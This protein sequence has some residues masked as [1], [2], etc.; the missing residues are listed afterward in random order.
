M[1]EWVIGVDLGRT[2]IALGLIDAQNRIIAHHRMPTRANEGAESV[3]AR[4]AQSVEDLR[5]VMPAHAAIR[6][7]GIC[8]PGPVDYDNGVIGEVHEMQGLHHAPLRAMLAQRL[9]LPVSLDHDAKAA[10]LGEFHYGAGKGERAMVYIVVGT[11]VGAAIISDGRIYRGVRNSAGEIGHV[12]LNR[13]GALCPCGSRGCV[14]TYLSGPWLARRY[15]HR[16]QR[17]GTPEAEASGELVTARAQHGE[18]IAVQVLHEAGEALGAAIA[19]LAM[20]LDIEL[21]VIGGSVVKAGDLL[22]NPAR[23]SLY[24]YAFKSV[25]ERLR[26]APSAMGDDAPILGCGWMARQTSQMISW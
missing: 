14:E 23:Q 5:G 9:A 21:Y 2:K 20:I 8:T 24:Q 19:S 7:L 25:A 13:D 26:I 12:S 17:A 10:A 16:R 15:E 22:L 6:A 3:V 18:P 1:E 11:G 4:I